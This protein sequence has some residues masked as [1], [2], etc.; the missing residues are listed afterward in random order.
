MLYVFAFAMKQE[1]DRKKKK[2]SLYNLKTID[3]KL[4]FFIHSV[5]S[6]TAM[7]FLQRKENPIKK[8]RRGV[9]SRSYWF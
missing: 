8:I 2:L 4:F 9:Q 1:A 6:E 5:H 7:I 3:V